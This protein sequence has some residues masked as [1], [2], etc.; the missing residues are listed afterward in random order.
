[1]TTVDAA[2]LVSAARELATWMLRDVEQRLAHSAGVAARAG[3]LAG[4]VASR[5]RQL[6]IAAAWL[7][8]IGY[9]PSARVTGLHS[10]DGAVFLAT[11]GWSPRLCGLV[12]HHSG[13]GFPAA[14][15]GLTGELAR[16]IHEESAVSDA[17]TYADQT[18]GPDGQPV[19][20]AERMEDMLA[21]HGSSSVQA[22]I[23]P[24]R[25][26]YLLAAASR[27]EQRLAAHG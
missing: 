17:L 1:V 24:V 6:L 11:R 22:R 20:L 10:Y 8:D 18:T 26:P 16:F 9:A 5:E 14:E 25:G 4:T 12:A 21:R 27:V 13:A 15:V 23:H 7:H 19:T 2:T 3:Q